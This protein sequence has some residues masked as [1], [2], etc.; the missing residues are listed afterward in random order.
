MSNNASAL[1]KMAETAGSSTATGPA[2][3]GNTSQT[4]I[5]G[6]RCSHIS[7]L[8]A[9]V[10]LIETIS[11]ELLPGQ[12]VSA[13]AGPYIAMLDEVKAEFTQASDISAGNQRACLDEP[14]LVD[15][16]APL[17]E[18]R[19][20]AGTVE[21]GEPTRKGSKLNYSSI[22]A[23][24]KSRKYELLS[25]NLEQTNEILKNWLQD[26]KEVHQYLMYH[27][28]TPEF[29]KSGW[30]EIVAEPQLPITNMTLAVNGIP[31]NALAVQAPVAMH[32][33]VHMNKMDTA[34]GSATLKQ[35][36]LRIQSPGQIERPLKHPYH[37]HGLI[38]LNTS[39][40]P[41]TDML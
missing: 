17:L 21:P 7:K 2:T 19:S 5:D 31:E 10:G 30:T 24:I 37:R 3:S 27:K 40:S 26:Q 41:T 14:A 33:S 29:H 13:V 34:G 38:S 12:R 20:R 9:N 25:P 36:I 16:E 6:Y 35:N 18:N 23:V 39:F 32:M 8:D 15:E 28:F 11:E 22:E 4:N 1:S